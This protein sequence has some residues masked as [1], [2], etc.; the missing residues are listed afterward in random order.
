MN[1]W[2]S[3]TYTWYENSGVVS[4]FQNRITWLIQYYKNGRLHR[5]DGPAEIRFYDNGNISHECYYNNGATHRDDGPA[6]TN[7]SY[8]SN[9][10]VIQ[11]L[12]YRH[13]KLHR[14]DGPAIE[15]ISWSYWFL[16]DNRVL[17]SAI[18]PV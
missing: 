6:K 4:R 17:T 9:G 2:V 10:A 5:E 18:N 16:N 12:Y 7:Y 13:G 3:P 8:S 14:E 1:T 11:D 15:G